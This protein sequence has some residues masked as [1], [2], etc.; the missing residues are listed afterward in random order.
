MRFHALACDYDGTLAHDG[1]VDEATVAALERVRASGRRLL[2]VTGRRLEPLQAIFPRLDLFDRVV[3][4]NGALI[5]DPA[6]GGERVLGEPPPARFVASLEARGVQPLEAGRVIVATWEPHES[7][8]L[9]VIRDLGLELQVIFNKGA[10]MVLPSGLNKGVGLLAAL[11]ELGLSR[12][13]VVGVGD[14]ENDHSFL[15]VCEQAVAVS[16]SVP[17]LRSH[18]DWTTRADHGA[19]VAELIAELLADD[20]QH[21]AARVDR[22]RLEIGATPGGEPLAIPAYTGT[23]LIAGTSGGGKSTLASS[24]LEQLQEQEYQVCIIDP[25]GD[26]GGTEG[27]VVLGDA[28]R[29]PLVSEIVDAV[30]EG[31]SAGAAA[32][33]NLLGISLAERPAFFRGLLARLLE[34]RGRTGRPHWLFIDEA[35]HLLPSAL[36]MSGAPL[37]EAPHGLLLVT[38]HPESVSRAVLQSVETLIVIGSTP[39]TTVADFA[40]A[41]G[42]DAPPVEAAPL[43]PGEGL[44]WQPGG[45]MPV[46]VSLR[47]PKAERRRHIRKYAAGD[48][49]QDASFHFRGP[50]ERL[51]LRAQNL[52][53]FLHLAEGV[54]DD[55]WSFHLAQGDYSRWFRERIKNE[56]L[57]GEAAAVEGDMRLSPAESR[58]AIKAAV[59]RHYTAPE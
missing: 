11:Q 44:V 16:N 26:Y 18:A 49:G 57:A 55:T 28:R 37:P 14:A 31:A 36:D 34:L 23:V 10:V 8:V 13:N 17:M 27:V 24:L 25:E 53:M 20:L 46:R 6:T 9:D 1:R 56:D 2:L 59:E 3:L 22:Q 38:V 12:H 33:A 19:G 54:D 35:H 47:A 5:L 21:R 45:G 51:N 29:A 15:S 48:I 32:A 30:A 43:A 40:R 39:R 58:A 4:E 52:Q 50:G 42:R 7:A 41:A